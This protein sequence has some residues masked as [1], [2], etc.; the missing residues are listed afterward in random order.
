MAFQQP[1][2][3]ARAVHAASVVYS[4]VEDDVDKLSSSVDSAVVVFGGT[5]ARPSVAAAA[6]SSQ[7]TQSS[8]WHVVSKQSRALSSLSD[9][10]SESGQSSHGQ[11]ACGVAQAQTGSMLPVH[12]GNGFFQQQHLSSEDDDH[13]SSPSYNYT[14][15]LAVTSDSGTDDVAS[16]DL[17]AIALGPTSP[18]TMRARR[19]QQ[20]QHSLALLSHEEEDQDSLASLTFSSSSSDDDRAGLVGAAETTM[21]SGSFRTAA[22]SWALTEAALSTIPDA[23]L[24]HHQADVHKASSADLTSDSSESPLSSEDES[25]V[26]VV[27]SRRGR[28]KLSQAH[29]RHQR[30][31]ATDEGDEDSAAAH[32]AD[33]FDRHSYPTPPP[34]FKT[35]KVSKRRHRQSGRARSSQ[36]KSSTSG[37]V[38][39]NERRTAV[40]HVIVEDNTM[41][42]PL[43]ESEESTASS[44]GSVPFGSVIEKVMTVDSETIEMVMQ[45]EPVTPGATPTP[46][47]STSPTRQLQST[48][49][50]R[51]AKPVHG[52]QALAQHARQELGGDM[53][54]FYLGHEQ[55]DDE[56]AGDETETETSHLTSLHDG[57]S[58]PVPSTAA[59]VA[60]WVH[61]ASPPV[62]APRPTPPPSTEETHTALPSMP[63]RSYSTSSVPAF[64]AA[65]SRS[66]ASATVRRRASFVSSTESSELGVR[67]RYLQK[68]AVIDDIDAES[69]LSSSVASS[70]SSS[71]WGGEFERFEAA[72]S[73][74]RRLFNKLRGVVDDVVE[75]HQPRSSMSSSALH[76]PTTE[77]SSLSTLKSSVVSSTIWNDQ[78]ESEHA[79]SEEMVDEADELE[80]SIEV[81][82]TRFQVRA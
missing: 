72:M 10:A 15:S 22:G 63:V 77:L 9:A 30:L 23:T 43:E 66:D 2:R 16:D 75:P 35:A 68:H 73:Y 47:R 20:Q 80:W 14:E 76:S 13:L 7:L 29:H 71:P 11:G 1:Q 65:L 79:P 57:L 37:S 60:R 33:R 69:D 8:S 58:T 82:A 26:G 41:D 51:H 64:L 40:G 55:E 49:R 27:G 56:D 48:P 42:T 81:K 32:S 28:R 70:T 50:S 6:A 61:S 59:P 39:G 36:K 62:F 52:L 24:Q 74:W 5:N 53:P 44:T 45:F 67:S 25:L 38:A 54:M 19:Q 78:D 46:S 31:A 21:S 3:R 12:D 17:V 34:E 18:A 4:D